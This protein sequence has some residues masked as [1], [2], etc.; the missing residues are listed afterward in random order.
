MKG[1]EFED[2]KVYDERKEQELFKSVKDK[3]LKYKM[4]EKKGTQPIKD[5]SDI[6]VNPDEYQIATI[7]GGYF[8]NLLHAGQL[9][10]GFGVLTASRFYYRG[11]AYHQLKWML[12]KTN[13]ES[14][15]ELQNIT[16]TG[17]VF[18]RNLILAAIAALVTLIEL[19]LIV[20]G[21]FDSPENVIEYLIV[22]LIGAC[23][24]VA[25]WALYIWYRRA[26][27]QVSYAGGTIA[28]NASAYDMKQLHDFDRRLHQAKDEKVEELLSRKERC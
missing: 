14:T 6:F 21:F 27:Y 5:V 20:I 3:G 16:A 25:L 24:T 12:Y 19:M 7:G 17:F 18:S 10:R 23:I 26:I 22:T 4:R 1:T 15:V 9:A 11:K 8:I 2:E 28:I 13:E